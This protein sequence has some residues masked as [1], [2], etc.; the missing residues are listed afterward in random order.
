[1][2]VAGWVLASRV[3][4]E[5][6]VPMIKMIIEDDEN[7]LGYGKGKRYRCEYEHMT[8]D[9]LN[10]VFY[11]SEYGCL[12]MKRADD[13][14]YDFAREEI[15]KALESGKRSSNEKPKKRRVAAT[16]KVTTTLSGELA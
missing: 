11:F 7:T 16:A 15:V 12:R 4:D 5:D 1:M 13:S 9:F 8:E 10:A 3:V 14:L 6:H 2:K